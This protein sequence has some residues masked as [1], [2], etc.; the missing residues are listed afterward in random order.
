MKI[1]GEL[2]LRNTKPDWLSKSKTEPSPAGKPIVLKSSRSMDVARQPP[3]DTHRV[4]I[5]EPAKNS[6]H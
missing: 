5:R 1:S 3:L 4:A 6:N 2:Q